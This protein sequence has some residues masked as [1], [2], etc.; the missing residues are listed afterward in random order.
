MQNNRRKKY[1]DVD[2][3]AS[4]NTIEDCSI[5]GFQN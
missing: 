4:S 2:G 5:Q 3:G 1:K